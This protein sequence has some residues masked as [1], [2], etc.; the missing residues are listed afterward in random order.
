MDFEG[1]SIFRQTHL[2]PFVIYR[3][4]IYIIILYIICIYILYVLLYIVPLYIRIDIIYM[5]TQRV[6]SVLW[7]VVF[8]IWCWGPK[9]TYASPEGQR[10]L[11]PTLAFVVQ[12]ALPSGPFRRTSSG[13][14]VV[15]LLLLHY[16]DL[17]GGFHKWWYPNSW[18][19][20]NGKSY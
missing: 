20:Y 6:T 7:H 4:Y 1:Y 8:Q 16:M 10:C 9:V 11:E 18:L 14:K 15:Q 5:Y 12:P 3:V 17:Y 2:I 13:S 19:V